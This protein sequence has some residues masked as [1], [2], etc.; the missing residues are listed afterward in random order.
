ML[1]VVS[2]AVLQLVVVAFVCV[3]VVVLLIAPVVDYRCHYNRSCWSRC[4]C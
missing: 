2:V 3:I 1:Y 4:C